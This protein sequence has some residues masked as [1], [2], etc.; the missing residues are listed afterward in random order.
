MRS[1][2]IKLLGVALGAALLMT[3]LTAAPSSALDGHIT[4]AVGDVTVSGRIVLNADERLG[5]SVA[6]RLQVTHSGASATVQSGRVTLTDPRG[7]LLTGAEFAGS[8]DTGVWTSK[9]LMPADPEPGLYEVSVDAQVDVTTQDG[10][11]VTVPLR[12]SDLFSA[13][14][15]VVRN[16]PKVWTSPSSVPTGATI[17]VSGVTN[18]RDFST[19]G[20][21][22]ATGQ[23][24]K[25]YFDPSG[26]APETLEATLTTDSRGFFTSQ[27]RSTSS[28][29]GGAEMPT[30]DA[31]ERAVARASSSVRARTTTLREGAVTRTKN[32]L[33][34]GHRLITHDVVVGLDPVKRRVGV[35]NLGYSLGASWGYVS[36][37]SR[38]GEGHYRDGY[39]KYLWMQA[40]DGS[41]ITPTFTFRP[42]LPAGVYD[43]GVSEMMKACSAPD[44]IERYSPTGNCRQD[45]LVEDST[46]TTIVVKRASI[47]TISASSTSFTGP[48]TITLRGAV[49]KVQ[50][51][52]N[53]EAAIRLSPNTP[54][55]L[56]FDPAGSAGPEYKKTVRTDSKGVYTTT[57]RTSVSGQWVAKYPGTD[58]QAP[59]KRA[60]TITVR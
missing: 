37:E 54:V 28:G 13:P 34:V 1:K 32:G 42:T 48:K 11:V 50:L 47:T 29:E 43:V 14:L 8:V 12:G 10:R 35:A 38:R 26:S 22:P 17:T 19:S 27:Q 58:L 49:R 18:M 44:W 55:K 40:D 52:S 57:A 25:L 3:G 46:V 36:V 24:V 33:T 39:V 41:T 60:V 20:Y 7:R 5:R 21:V 53:T 31:G 16:I 23:K 45:I 4:A 2:A 9:V 59:S 15:R 6:P 51:V 30:T 56:Y